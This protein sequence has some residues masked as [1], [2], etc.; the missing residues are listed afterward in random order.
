[1]TAWSVYLIRGAGGMIYTGIATDVERRLG[2]HR[3]GRGAKY[4]R[5]RGPLRVVYR[6][7]LGSR[8]LAQSIEYR[9]KALTKT[10]KQA[11]VRA[12]PSRKQLLKSLEPITRS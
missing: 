12:A 10:E 2:E 8:S 6:R 5:G 7:K 9:L 1:M 11:I 3:A 4:L